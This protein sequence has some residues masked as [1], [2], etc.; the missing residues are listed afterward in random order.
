M[1]LVF[2]VN[3]SSARPESR[4]L[5]SCSCRNNS[6]RIRSFQ[7]CCNHRAG[8]K[9]RTRRVSSIWRRGWDYCEHPVRSL[10]GSQR[11]RCSLQSAPG[12]LL[13]QWLLIPA[14]RQQ[15]KKTRTRRVS[16][17]WRR[18]WDSNPRRALTLA[19]FQDQCIQPLCHLSIGSVDVSEAR[20]S[21]GFCDAAPPRI[22]VHS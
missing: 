3:V 11:R 20:N 9:A 5:V 1:V 10:S 7:V 16:S 2:N 14:F 12:G 21:N 6:S 17:I 18:G 13:E 15:I 8:R 22:V 19:G 4:L